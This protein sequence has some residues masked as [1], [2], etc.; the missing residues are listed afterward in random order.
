MLQLYNDHFPSSTTVASSR[1]ALRNPAILFA[2]FLFV[3]KYQ[4]T[5]NAEAIKLL[6]FQ[7]IFWNEVI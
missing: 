2:G 4:G 6:L 7:A 3:Q 5:N 1:W